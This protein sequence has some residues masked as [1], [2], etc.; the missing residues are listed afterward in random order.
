MKMY[1]KYWIKDRK[2]QQCFML[3]YVMMRII[4]AEK[5]KN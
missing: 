1:G 2:K 5:R 4:S 3:L